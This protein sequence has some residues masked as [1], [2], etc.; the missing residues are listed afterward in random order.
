MKRNTKLLLILGTSIGVFFII[1]EIASIMQ[2]YNL[3][4]NCPSQMIN[5]LP[6]R[7]V[8]IIVGIIIIAITV[9][10]SLI[11]EKR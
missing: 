5:I 4:P 8:I 10:L 6:E 11:I 2:V 3:C 7:Y 1:F 9:I